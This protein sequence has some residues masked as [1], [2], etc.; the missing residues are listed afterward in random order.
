MTIK[1][2]LRTKVIELAQQKKGR[3]E[4]AYELNLSQGSVSNILREWR[5]GKDQTINAI[6]STISTGILL[7][8]DAGSE[9]EKAVS[10]N[11][12]EPDVDF[13]DI[14][15]QEN[16][17]GLVNLETELEDLKVKQDLLLRQIEENQRV[18]ETNREA[19]DDFLAVKEEMAKCGIEDG[20]TEFVK[21]IQI[22][23]KYGHDPSKIM[24][25]FCEVQDVIMEKE[26]IK[27]LKEETEHKLQVLERKLEQ[28]GL[29]DFDRLRRVVVAI[30]TLETYGI[31]V[32]Q[33][34]GYYQNQRVLTKT[35][36]VYRGGRVVT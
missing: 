11:S 21:V 1:A 12:P 2:E 23:R 32:E 6:N 34:I 8:T 20:S 4:I 14:S 33:I 24:N 3:N 9:I 25:S 17:P 15:Y 19:A 10:S 22:F 26:R 35:R 16:Y 29:G 28:I 7:D 13:S 27:T 31:G 36:S 5:E 30:M 18:L